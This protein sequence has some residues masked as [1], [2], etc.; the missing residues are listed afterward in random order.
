MMSSLGVR[1]KFAA[2][3]RNILKAKKGSEI[4]EEKGE[5]VGE[6]DDG[7]NEV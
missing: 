1:F 7:L 6:D 4:E 3:L 2:C 5:D